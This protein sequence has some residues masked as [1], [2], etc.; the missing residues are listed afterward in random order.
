[1]NKPWFYQH[2]L[3]GF[4]LS[5]FTLWFSS[6]LS[7]VDEQTACSRDPMINE[8]QAGWFWFLLGQI[9]LKRR[10][11]YPCK[12]E[13]LSVPAPCHL[14]HTHTEITG[15]NFEGCRWQIKATVW[16]TWTAIN[17]SNVHRTAWPIHSSSTITQRITIGIAVGCLWIKL[18]GIQSS[19]KFIITMLR[20]TCGISTCYIVVSGSATER[21]ARRIPTTGRLVLSRPAI[22]RFAASATILSGG[23]TVIIPWA[24]HSTWTVASC[25]IADNRTEK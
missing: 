5:W 11:K 21:S 25:F 4:I 3:L 1:M 22:A 6:W 20:S 10:I 24:T 8:S 23:T 16:T 18:W 14:H 19:N 15:N 7:L 17:N 2:S 13:Y 9:Y 12:R